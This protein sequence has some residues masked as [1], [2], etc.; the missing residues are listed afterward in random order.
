M[1]TPKMKPMLKYPGGKR[2]ELSRILPLVPPF[3]RYIEPFL[4]GGALF[5]ALNPDL[6]LIA[7][8]NA[9]LIRF[10]LEVRDR[11]DTVRDDLQD[12]QALY[13]YYRQQYIAARAYAAPGERVHDNNEAL[14]YAMRDELNGRRQRAWSFAA[15]YFYINHTAYAGMVRHNASGDFNVPFGR[16][17]SINAD[18]VTQ[19]HAD[20]L[21]NAEINCAD[22][23]AT[24]QQAM[25]GDFIFLDPPY[26][27][28]FSDYGGS[29]GGFTGDDH[30]RLAR[31]FK[32]TPAKALMVISE[33]P[34][35][36]QLYGDYIFGQ[37]PKAYAVNIK[38]RFRAAANHLIIANYDIPQTPADAQQPPAS[39]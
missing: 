29:K 33:S 24:M 11:F 2:R 30:R 3:T 23:A 14:Y 17:A 25:P 13:A 16:Y 34:L 6:A 31:L 9:R 27:A 39:P 5:F 26:D 1:N 10:Y 36:R 12:I 22:F 19:R 4:G 38:N 8:N 15:T 37:Y 32:D 7:G 28:P 21:Q 18:L 20:A 35:M